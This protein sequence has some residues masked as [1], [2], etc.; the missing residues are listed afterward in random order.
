MHLMLEFSE[1]F[2]RKEVPDP[3]Y[4]DG[5]FDDVFNMITDAS[6]GLL[7]EIRQKYGI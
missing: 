2:E 4:G 3:Y 6:Q 1:Q 5:G 7:Y